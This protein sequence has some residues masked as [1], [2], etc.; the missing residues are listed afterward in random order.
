MSI[1][2]I[3]RNH[4]VDP[5]LVLPTHYRTLSIRVEESKI[6]DAEGDK[7]GRKGDIDFADIVW[8][9][10]SVQ[11]IL[12]RLSSSPTQGLSNEQVAKRLKQHGPNRPTQP[13]SRCFQRILGYLFGGFGP[14]LFIAAILVFVAWKPLEQPPQ[15]SNLAL[16]IVLICVFF[17]QAAFSFYQDFSSS[18]VMASIKTM[19]PDHCLV[20]RDG[21]RQNIPGA[22]IVPGDLLC[23]KMGDR[24]PADVRFIEVS[25]DARFDRAILTGETAPLHGCVDSTDDNYLETAC[26]GL[27]GTHCVVGSTLG[28]VVATGDRTVFGRIAK[29]TAPPKQGQTSL[30]REIFHFVKIV[31]GMMLSMIFVVLIVWAAWLRRSH[32]TW[33]SVPQLIVDCVT[34]AVAFV[35]EGL[36]IAVTSSL[37][38]TASIMKR[39]KILCKSLQTVETLGSV[40]VICSD[41]TGTLTENQMTVTECMVGRCI[42]TAAQAAKAEGAG[43]DGPEELGI[44][45][46]LCN[47]SEFDATT[48]DQPLKN[49]KI[50]GDATDQAILRFAE[51]IVPVSETRRQF[52][53]IYKIAFNSKNKFM[54]QIVQSVG[55]SRLDTSSTDPNSLSPL[56]LTIKGAPDILIARCN[57]VMADNGKY[58]RPITQDDRNFVE[59]TKNQWSSQG[60]RVILLA[61]KKLPVTMRSLSTASLEYEQRT[62]EEASKELEFVGLVA[63]LDPPRDEIPQV[64]ETLRGAGIRVFMVTGDFKLTALAIA[65]QCGIITQPEAVDDAMALS[66]DDRSSEPPVSAAEK[67]VQ[68][69]GS[70]GIALSGVEINQ[71]GGQEWD[72]LCNYQEIVFARTTPE[73]KLRIVKE[74]QARGKVVGM[75]GDGVNDAPSLKAAD[76]GIAMGSGSEV[77]MEA[78][79][80]VLLDSFSAIIEA[81]KYGRVVFDNL[82]KTICYLMP[83]G[84]FSEFWPIF[85]NVLFGMPQILSSFLMIIICCFTDCAA[86]TV[87][88]YERPE[89]DVLARKPRNMKKDR[90][91]N[92]K[93]FLQAYGFLGTVMALCSF[94]V[95]YWHAERKGILLKQ[96]VLGF[97]RVP[98]GMSQAYFTKVLDESSSIYFINLVIMQIFNLLAIRTRR[99]SLLQ[100]PPLFRPETQNY[101][102]FPAI[103]FALGVAFLFLYIPK[104]QTVLG[105]SNIPVENF[106]LPVAF[107]MGLL[108]LDEARKAAVRKW[109]QE[110]LAKIA[111]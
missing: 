35:P 62:L 105:S 61:R 52:K 56:L 44:M 28:L 99:L 66:S 12:L 36:P 102:L 86:A 7:T 79:D 34:I 100:H 81:I 11:E 74:F 108:L 51:S 70:R 83:A 21:A 38:I 77:A 96:L 46:G 24:L 107:G 101:K 27:A 65:A 19:L 85:T 106:F 73:Q 50:N 3:S 1:R 45:G 82:K 93:L 43:N 32:P 110:F 6:R 67:G 59:E 64:I 39:N 48:M 9:K 26:I 72:S 42:M 25:T 47:A 109:P 18:R 68:V 41:K 71:L 16:A 63:I 57:A 103:L 8:H 30:Q 5:G 91:V 4:T 84:T 23:I 60:R 49:R 94:A 37:T 14:I 40:S 104:L 80:M 10:L 111:W 87:I 98:N 29:L 22:D 76:I 54:V 75:T 69:L 89:R 88:A 78:A 2:T 33:I 58:T 55:L 15:Q 90:L 92:G 20:F 95:S 97:G 13:S 31:V 53:T 17:A